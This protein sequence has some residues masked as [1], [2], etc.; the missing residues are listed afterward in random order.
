MHTH[1][2][3]RKAPA[4]RD[5]GEME[6]RGA[7]APR[8][9]AAQMEERVWCVCRMTPREDIRIAFF[10]SPRGRFCYCWGTIMK[11]SSRWSRVL[12]FWLAA[13]SA[14]HLPALALFGQGRVNFANSSS[15]QLTTNSGFL[16]PL[17]QAP[18]ASGPT[19]GVNTYLIGLY[20]AP[21]GTTDPNAFAL[22]GTATN[23]TVPVNNGRFNGGSAFEIPGNTGQT[24][25]FQIRAWSTYAGATYE[26]AFLFSG[27]Y[28]YLGVSAVGQVTPSTNGQPP[29]LFGTSAGQVGGF[30]LTP[31]F[32]IVP[33]EV[34]ITSPTNGSLFPAPASVP[35]NVHFYQTEGGAVSLVELFTN[36]VL[37]AQKSSLTNLAGSGNTSFMLSN[38]TAGHYL[39]RAR[40]SSWLMATSTP[41]TV[42][43]ADR[44]VLAFAPGSNG[45]IQIHFNSAT[46]INYVVERGALT[47]FSPI[48]TNPGTATPISYS[49]TNGSATQRTY[50]V[51]LQ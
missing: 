14:F 5:D 49:E 42:R 17:G 18:N 13:A 21:Q 4:L 51:R 35:V 9:G 26:E 7:G 43:V 46:G 30:V 33:P 28:R 37:A 15:T 36:G 1:E 20:I 3:E 24:I 47:S 29:A 6:T 23:G 31:G 34:S 2:P 44:P 41:V 48:I 12:V 32:T 8:S 50:R 19:T 22:V 45:P 10:V 39:L 25:A 11:T 38:L 16:P 40:A 27:G